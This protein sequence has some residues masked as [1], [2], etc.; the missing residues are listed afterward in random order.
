MPRIAGAQVNTGL[1]RAGV[2][3]A[4]A[5]SYEPV[6]IM[7]RFFDRAPLKEQAVGITFQLQICGGGGGCAAASGMSANITEAQTKRS[8][9]LVIFASS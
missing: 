5:I 9:A 4:L 8:N 1:F 3:K 7:L 2:D 6:T